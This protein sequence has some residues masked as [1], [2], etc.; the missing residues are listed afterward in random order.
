M[1]CRPKARPAVPV[2][3]R[4]DEL[5]A[6]RRAHPLAEAVDEAAGE[7]HRPDEGQGEDE[8]ADGAEAVTGEHERPAPAGVV[9]PACPKGYRV[10]LAVA[11]A[12]PS[13]RPSTATGAPSTPVMKYGKSG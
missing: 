10:M 9:G 13:M 5:V 1:R 6:R 4:G 7:R 2:V 3:L 11:S 8:L 12:M